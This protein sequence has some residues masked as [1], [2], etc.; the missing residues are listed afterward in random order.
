MEI[1]SPKKNQ[2]NKQKQ[3]NKKTNKQ[4][5]TLSTELKS[6]QNIQTPTKLNQTSQNQPSN[7]E[8]L[9]YLDTKVLNAKDFLI[10]VSMRW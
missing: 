10:V 9:M 3:T 4:K 5:T 6:S 2:P 7:H 1:S 8:T